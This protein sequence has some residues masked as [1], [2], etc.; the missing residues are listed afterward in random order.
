MSLAEDVIA[1]LAANTERTLADN[2]C[3]VA[4][5]ASESL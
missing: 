2:R 3:A 1:S 5:T 4:A